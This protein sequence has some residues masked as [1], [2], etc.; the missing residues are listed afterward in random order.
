MLGHL[1]YFIFRRHYRILY[2]S[3]FNRTSPESTVSE[4]AGWKYR[5]LE[6]VGVAEAAKKK[7]AYLRFL[8]MVEP[9][10]VAVEQDAAKKRNRTDGVEEEQD[11]K[12]NVPSSVLSGAREKLFD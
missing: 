3:W 7:K 2:G 10:G 9:R 11:E 5:S 6:A 1:R 12:K 4:Y 8:D